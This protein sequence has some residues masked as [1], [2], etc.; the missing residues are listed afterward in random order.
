MISY[1]L[2]VLNN[3]EMPKHLVKIFIGAAK[4]SSFLALLYLIAMED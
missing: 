3:I 4:N 2:L 1:A